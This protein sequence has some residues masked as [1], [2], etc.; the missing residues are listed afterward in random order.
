MFPSDEVTSKETPELAEY[1]EEDPYNTND[2]SSYEKTM[3][4]NLLADD[5][6]LDAVGYSYDPKNAGM[7]VED[8]GDVDPTRESALG[9]DGD[10]PYFSEDNKGNL[11]GTTGSQPDAPG[12][13][14]DYIKGAKDKDKGVTGLNGSQ[15]T[16][17]DPIAAMAGQAA[18]SSQEGKSRKRRPRKQ[19]RPRP[20]KNQTGLRTAKGVAAIH[21][22]SGVTKPQLLPTGT[23]VGFSVEYR[24]TR[25]G[26][27]K[28]TKYIWVIRSRSGKTMA[29][30]VPIKGEGRLQTVI[31]EFRPDDKPFQTM[32][33][34]VKGSIRRQ[35]CKSYAFPTI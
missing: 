8:P 22:S 7:S 6:D 31:P 4:E 25:L 17:E 34:E 23:G 21:L 33:L 10:D 5:I 9:G 13:I 3:G 15:P 20:A 24:F 26:P 32:I 27:Q 29:R 12:S 18:S 30:Q 16:A 28:G 1:D 14:D 35:I 2:T 19:A 11:I